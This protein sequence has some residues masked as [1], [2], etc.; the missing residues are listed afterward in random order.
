M[1]GAPTLESEGGLFR[2]AGCYNTIMK[3]FLLAIVFA[4]SLVFGTRGM[5]R[6]VNTD[7][8]S[9]AGFKADISL[10]QR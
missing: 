2:G 1:S 10:G 5:V 8:F 7:N 9:V 4:V 3:R 6:V